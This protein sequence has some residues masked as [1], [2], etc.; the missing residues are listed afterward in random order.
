MMLLGSQKVN[1]KGHLEIGGCDTVDLARRFGTPLY[2]MDEAFL[3]ERCREYASAFE[4]EYGDSAIAYA[5]K[6]FVVAAMCALANQEGMWL[7]VASA[8]ELHTARVAG[9]PME[10]VVFHGNYK[11]REELEMAVECGVRFVVP[12]SFTELQLLNTIAENAGKT[13]GVMLRCNPG[14]DPHT[15]RLIRTGQEDSKF[16]FNI[17]NGAAMEAAKTV[18][19]LK[20]LKLRGIHCHVGSQ[21]FDVTPFVEAAP[22]MVNFIKDIGAPIEV[23]DMGGGLGVRYLEEHNPPTIDDSRPILTIQRNEATISTGL[24]MSYKD[25]VN[26]D[27]WFGIAAG[28]AKLSFPNATWAAVRCN[29]SGPIPR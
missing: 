13:Q 22:V 8:G 5:S 11:S 16:G 18:L 6:A 28:K 19:G 21:I 4:R 17:K 29:T 23:L 10:R 24:W 12:D 14:V 15:H 7:D 26:S 25:A 2:V 27:S 1:D 9:F 3:R 20:G